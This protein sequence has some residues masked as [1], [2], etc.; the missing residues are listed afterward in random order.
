M[1]TTQTRTKNEQQRFQSDGKRDISG[2]MIDATYDLR[3]EVSRHQ[4]YKAKVKALKKIE[5]DPDVQYS[6]LWS[7][8][9]ELRK[10][11]PG[12]TI[13]LGTT[14]DSRFDRFYVCWNAMKRGFLGGCRPLLGVDG[15][16][17]K[18][19][20]GGILLT[21][22]GVDANNNLFPVAYAV[23]EKENGEIWD[24]FL[25][26]LKRDLEI[27]PEE[28][29]FM[30]DKQ[31][32][33]IQA[34]QT[35][36]PGSEHRFCVRH[37]HNNLKTA[38]FRGLAFKQAL[39]K[40][41]CSTTNGE[42][43]CRMEEMRTLNQAA[44]EWFNNKPPEQWSKA[45][46]SEKS[47][48]DML[49]NNVC[50]SFNANILDARDKSII[51]MLEW[52]REYLMKRLQKNRDIASEKWK[53][54]LCPRIQ[55]NVDQNTEKVSDCIPIKGN[56]HH[57]QIS[58]F[59]GEQFTVDLNKYE[60][61][62]RRWQLTGIPCTHAICALLK[63]NLDP[64]TYVHDCYTVHSYL[65]AYELPIFGISH[66]LLWGDSLYIPP[67]PPNFGRRGTRGRQSTKRRPEPFEKENDG[68][69]K[70]VVRLGSAGTWVVRLRQV[71]LDLLELGQA[72]SDYKMYLP[73]E[74]VE[75]HFETILALDFMKDLGYCIALGV[76][77]VLVVE[78]AS[79]DRTIHLDH[80]SFPCSSHLPFVGGIDS[81]SNLGQH[82]QVVEEFLLLVELKEHSPCPKESSSMFA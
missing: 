30:S 20:Y 24:W 43:K 49:L 62:C 9:E 81:S 12:S 79:L 65:K 27:Q 76:E 77:E 32:G 71:L 18:S 72:H 60:C 1:Y 38:G 5:G 36:F 68:Q 25:T 14:E 45:F 73:P 82:L 67:L 46:F 2:F 15:C 75:E 42:F 44:W 22:V 6:K 58:C 31:K 50:E 33:L 16:H 40:A 28:F 51:T 37:L 48:C 63:Q 10:T 74:I 57:Y 26:I 34:F 64:V 55:K 7:Y 41:A 69:R 53:G 52:I 66:D 8:A 80:C 78:L 61:T 47:K 3:C 19:K 29:T 59:G 70:G 39:W 56:N 17:L 13:I 54:Q 21:S 35:V 23:V 11:N 4:A